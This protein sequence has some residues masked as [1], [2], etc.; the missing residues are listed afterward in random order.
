MRKL[1][2]DMIDKGQLIPKVSMSQYY[3]TVLK[4]F[5]TDETLIK[6]LFPEVEILA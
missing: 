5:G 6:K 4:W 2:D 1:L 3:N